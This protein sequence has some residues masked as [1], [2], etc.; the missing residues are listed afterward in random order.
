MFESCGAL[1][2]DIA[3]SVFEGPQ[4]DASRDYG[5]FNAALVHTPGQEADVRRFFAAVR[6]RW[7][8]PPPAF[9]KNYMEANRTYAGLLAK[10]RN[11]DHLTAFADD[12]YTEI[13]GAVNQSARAELL[14][15]NETLVAME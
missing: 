4:E 9:E 12:I 1:G 5:L 10:V 6:N 15:M 11:D 13:A 8:P 7:F 2:E 14:A 3:I